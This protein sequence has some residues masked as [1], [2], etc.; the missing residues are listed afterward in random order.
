MTRVKMAIIIKDYKE[1]KKQV[2]CGQHK[3]FIYINQLYY[4]IFHKNSFSNI[5]CNRSRDMT[6]K[7]I[8][9]KKM[10]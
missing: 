6:I 10:E 5:P 2:R 4:I 8:L 3:T 9:E 7:N 1:D